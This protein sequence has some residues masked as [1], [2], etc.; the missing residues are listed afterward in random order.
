MDISSR[1]FARLK[2]PSLYWPVYLWHFLEAVRRVGKQRELLSFT[3]WELIHRLHLYQ[4]R[5]RYLNFA[6]AP[7]QLLTGESDYTSQQVTPDLLFL[8]VAIDWKYCI[9]T[10]SG[11]LWGSCFSDPNALYRSDDQS[12]SA[13]LLHRFPRPITSLF[14]SSR[15]TVFVCSDGAIHRSEDRGTHLA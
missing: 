3:L 5:N 6:E 9:E 10:T 4:F 1:Y 11:L 2:S 12:Q 13:T 14:I 15:H 8:P 7:Y